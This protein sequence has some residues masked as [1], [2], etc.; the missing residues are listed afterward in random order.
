MIAN[1]KFFSKWKVKNL[2]ANTLEGAAVQEWVSPFNFHLLWFWQLILFFVSILSN[3]QCE[4]VQATFEINS[5]SLFSLWAIWIKGR[6][7]L[8][9]RAAEL[10]VDCMKF[11]QCSLSAHS[12]A[13]LNFISNLYQSQRVSD[14][15]R[16]PSPWASGPSHKC[17]FPAEALLLLPQLSPAT[18][19]ASL[20]QLKWFPQMAKFII[21]ITCSLE[22]PFV[23]V[24]YLHIY[25][26]HH[27]VSSLRTGTRSDLQ[28]GVYPE[29]Q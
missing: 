25:L 11:S 17:C 5:L 9:R 15:S 16:A 24:S 10:Q 4:S 21:V 6:K 3:W 14:R 26:L 20:L 23:S 13:L 8:W 29:V 22:F 1:L 7:E 2:E 18:Y 28:P 12:L 19:T 27:K